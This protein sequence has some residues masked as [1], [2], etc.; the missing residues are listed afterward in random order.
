MN[1]HV[2]FVGSL[3][4]SGSR[5]APRYKKGKSLTYKSIFPLSKC[6]LY[7]F[8]KSAETLLEFSESRNGWMVNTVS[9]ILCESN[10][11]VLVDTTY[12]SS[13]DMHTPRLDI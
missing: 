1:R 13:I 7:I 10:W 8:L 6:F 5:G 2:I 11:C 4:P 3:I 12:D 9:E